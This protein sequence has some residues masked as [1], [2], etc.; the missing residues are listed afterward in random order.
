[1]RDLTS[2][3][4]RDLKR[5]A[6]ATAIAVVLQG[7]SLFSKDEDLNP[8]APLPKVESS[9][10]ADTLWRSS[11]GDGIGN[12]YSQLRPVVEDDVIYA[13]ARDGDVTAFERSTG[14]AL[15]SVDLADLPVNA[16]KRSARLSGG[17]V[18][19]YGKLF[20]GSENGQVYALSE[21]NGE[22]LW[23]TNV[24]GEVV[25]S[26]AVEDGRVVVL[27]T[28]G[29]LVALDTD[30]GKLQWTLAEEQPP[31]TLRSTG[32]PVITNGAVLYG[33]ADGKVGIALLG[34]GQP[35]R[36]S[37][38]ADPR[39]ATELDRMVDVDAAPLIA[40]DELYAIAYNGQ[41]MARKLMTGDEVWKRKYSGY[42]DMAVT[43]NAIVLTDSRSHLFAIDR[44]NG[45][46][47]WSN[48]QLENRSVTAPVIFGD[49][50]VVGD[51]EGYLYWLDR[52]DGTIQAM[53]QL[54]SSGLYAAP[55]VDDETLYV[56]SRDGKLYA[57]KRP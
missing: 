17:L 34:N 38:V 9:F 3:L 49:Y 2:G 1:M 39:G 15:W 55:L 26:P 35:V 19:R 7:C 43:G 56:Q 18:S 40:G 48:T 31:L 47:L 53:Q 11:V 30:E 4:Q 12:F 8:M 44:R 20:L 22:V 33:R 10:Q 29:R 13:A 16:D 21:E 50:V 45:L 36:Q 6:L 42:R 51:V 5:V 41:L 14:K 24:P 25:A 37:K 46:E 54:D 27:T 32:A 23:Q 28:S 52:S 57:L